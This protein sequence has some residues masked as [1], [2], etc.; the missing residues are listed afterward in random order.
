M[1]VKKKGYTLVE[2]MI[3]VAII[4]VIGGIGYQVFNR[5]YQFYRL[6]SART[7]IQRE[8][9]VIL[10]NMNRKMRQAVA[11]TANI[12]QDSG[13]PP[14]SRITFNTIDGSTITYKQ[15]GRTLY[16]VVGERQTT[17]SKNLQYIAFTY[18]ETD[19]NTVMSISL[20]LEKQTYSMRDTALQMAITKVRL[21]N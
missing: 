5:F 17:L 7:E 8:I 11:N 12:Y 6:N 4:G 16:E 21:M 10:D 2:A 3:T 15:V 14:Y 1:G 20:T 13:Q 18:P 19:I 9:R